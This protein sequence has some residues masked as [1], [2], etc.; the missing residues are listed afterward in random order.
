MFRK[1]LKLHTFTVRHKSGSAKPFQSAWN[2][3][4]RKHQK[5]KFPHKEVAVINISDFSV[6]RQNSNISYFSASY[7]EDAFWYLNNSV[8]C[9]CYSVC[10]PG[11]IHGTCCFTVR[12]SCKP[13]RKKWK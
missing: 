7:L 9:T 11:E 1:G 6:F 2:F 13:W 12:A 10:L 5:T 8:A 4:I 3:C